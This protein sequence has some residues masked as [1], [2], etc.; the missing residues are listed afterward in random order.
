MHTNIL[1]EPSNETPQVILNS[2]AGI[3]KF[4]GRS[5]PA[6][7]E[8]FYNPILEW[9][10]DYVQ[11]PAPYTAVE[12]FLDFYNT[13]SSKCIFDIMRELELIYHT[14]NKLSVKWVYGQEDTESLEF[15]EM[16]EEDL[17]IVI[18]KES[19]DSN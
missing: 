17:K 6:N 10:K 9:I 12:C 13:R 7:T 5:L 2:R 8:K 14:G 16:I 18:Q 15:A 3:I 4:T 1:I 19:V 11:H